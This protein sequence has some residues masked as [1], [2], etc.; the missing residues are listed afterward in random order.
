MLLGAGLLLTSFAKTL[1]VD[2]G[3]KAD[4]LLTANMSLPVTRYKDDASRMQLQSQ[5]LERVRAIPGVTYA[6]FSSVIPMSGDFD[7]SVMSAEG[8][9]A[10][11]NESVL[12]PMRIFASPGFFEAMDIK[13]V[14]GRGFNDTDRQ[15]SQQVAVIDEFLANKYF[16]GKDPIGKRVCQCVPGLELSKD[17]IVWKTVVGVAKTIRMEGLTGDQTPGQYYF[18]YPQEMTSHMYLIVRTSTEPASVIS[19]VRA[20]VTSIDPDLPLYSV[21][22]MQEKLSA[23]L[24]TTRIRTILIV[25]FGAVAVLLAA[26]GIYG[27][28]AYSVAQRRAE[29][30]VRLALGSPA[31]TVFNLIV[32]QGMTLLAGGLV[33]G[34]LAALYLSRL[35]QGLLYGI[36][37]TDPVVYGVVAI[38][39]SAVALFACAIPARRA[40]RVEPGVA[41]RG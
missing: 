18:A 8:Y 34:G 9:V 37:A 11:P 24:T 16:A 15:N 17:T 25:G 31:S 1:G 40:M 30:G 7:S 6:A 28:L 14:K 22:T 35:V 13:I 32:K 36:T 10:Q 12:S 3:F 19:S 26:I 39:L 33:I 21:A 2:P 4:H 5:V 29:I 23:S 41:L 27:V 38:V 20:A